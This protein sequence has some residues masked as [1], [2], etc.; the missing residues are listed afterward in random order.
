MS[1][2][3]AIASQGESASKWR[4][5]SKASSKQSPPYGTMFTFKLSQSAVVTWSFWQQTGGRTVS[6]ICVARTSQN[7]HSPAC[8]RGVSA[9]SLTLK[10]R[11]GIVR[12]FFHGGLANRH[13]LKPGSYTVLI[14]ATNPAHQASN[15]ASLSFTATA[16]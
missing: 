14:T 4:E 9:G 16:S 3:P 12:V 10:E 11:A 2:P 15:T 6:G 13:T 1:K 8:T 5:N 7:R